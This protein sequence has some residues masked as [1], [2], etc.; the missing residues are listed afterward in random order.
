MPTIYQSQIEEKRER[1]AQIAKE[2][3][4]YH[5]PFF[6]QVWIDPRTG[7][8]TDSV[9]SRSLT[10]DIIEIEESEEESD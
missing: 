5:E 9:A 4:W 7:E 1:W 3:G 10:Q 2:N 6:V 8:I